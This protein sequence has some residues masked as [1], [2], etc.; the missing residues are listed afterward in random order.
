MQVIKA[1]F[2]LLLSNLPLICTLFFFIYF[3]L[4][5]RFEID[6]ASSEDASGRIKA[7][8]SALSAF[9]ESQGLT[10]WVYL[11]VMFV[12]YLVVLDI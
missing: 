7:R 5:T 6:I 11:I 2:F 1:G 8:L 3:P 4:L 10:G 12:M 9:A